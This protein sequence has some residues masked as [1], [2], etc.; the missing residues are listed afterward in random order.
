MIGSLTK[1]K[2]FSLFATPKGNRNIIYAICVMMAMVMISMAASICSRLYAA[3]KSIFV[4]N[5]HTCGLVGL[6]IFIAY[7]IRIRQ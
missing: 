3:S 2:S 5:I 4:E 6:M 7:S 1:Q